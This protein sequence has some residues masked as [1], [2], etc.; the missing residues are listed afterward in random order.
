MS[1]YQSN[2]VRTIAEL[3]RWDMAKAANAP[4]I[5]IGRLILAVDQTGNEAWEQ[6]INKLKQDHGARK[7][8]LYSGRHGAIE[9]CFQDNGEVYEGAAHPG[10]YQD[11]LRE[12][13]RFE[14]LANIDIQVVDTGRLSKLLYKQRV[15]TDIASGHWVIVSWCN[16][17]ASMHTRPIN[18]N[19]AADYLEGG[20]LFVD[21]FEMTRKRICDVV[22]EDYA[23][24]PRD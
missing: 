6:I 12:A 3:L 10:F 18:A 24:V 5:K 2:E 19:A 21:A 13:N 14:R 4:F 1:Y 20:V 9:G 22:I 8:K 16:S 15:L 23:W 7:F 17:I 11:D